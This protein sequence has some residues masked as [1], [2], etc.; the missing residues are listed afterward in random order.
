MLL[1]RVFLEG[2]VGRRG[3]GEHQR[4]VGREKGETFWLKHNGVGG[5]GGGRGVP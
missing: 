2:G 4:G 3:R 5:G 1:S